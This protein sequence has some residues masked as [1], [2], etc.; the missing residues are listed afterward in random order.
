MA[1]L[2][3]YLMKNKHLVKLPEYFEEEEEVEEVNEKDLEG[4]PSAKQSMQ[5]LSMPSSNAN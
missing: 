2:A 5:N 3:H 4:N 1:A